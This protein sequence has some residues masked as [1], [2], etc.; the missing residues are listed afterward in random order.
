MRSVLKVEV[1][2][3]AGVISRIRSGLLMATVCSLEGETGSG[4]L[5]LH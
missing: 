2:A 3:V 4:G 1:E 5:V